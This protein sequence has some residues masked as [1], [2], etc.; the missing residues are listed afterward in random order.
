[1]F[2]SHQKANGSAVRVAAE[3]V[4]K[5]FRWTDGERWR[6][7]IMKRTPSAVV[8]ARL[9]QGYARIDKLDNI[10]AAN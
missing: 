4:I 2:V 7:F 6:F 3:A 5:L 9:T 8:L 1:M 10:C